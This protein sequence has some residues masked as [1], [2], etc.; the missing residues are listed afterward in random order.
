MDIA[1]DEIWI[2]E[3]KS[4]SRESA[5]QISA[6]SVEIIDEDEIRV[7]PLK[8]KHLKFEKP[9]AQSPYQPTTQPANQS[10]CGESTFK[11][12]AA[13]SG[14]NLA[15]E[16]EQLRRDVKELQTRLGLASSE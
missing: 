11:S 1:M 14:Q 15:E 7:E 8:I 4:V 9:S 2:R 16:V 10:P 5:R 12:D 6:D 13:V 3:L